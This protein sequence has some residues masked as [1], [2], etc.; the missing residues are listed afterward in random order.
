MSLPDLRLAR[1]TAKLGLGTKRLR[2]GMG[3]KNMFSL[4]HLKKGL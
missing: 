3:F 4:S 2:V 1:D